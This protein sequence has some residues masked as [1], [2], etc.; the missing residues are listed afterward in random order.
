VPETLRTHVVGDVTTASD[1]VGEG[2]LEVSC[3]VGIQPG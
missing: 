3:H 1:G 2:D